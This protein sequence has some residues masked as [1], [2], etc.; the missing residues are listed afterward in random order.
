VVHLTSRAAADLKLMQASMLLERDPAAAAA[1]AG[2]IL[3]ELPD[4]EAAQLLFAAARRRL[5][6]GASALG[7]L[8]SLSEANPDSAVLKLELGRS[9]AAAHD[10]TSALAALRAAVALN[11]NLAQGWRELSQLHF[12]GG[13]ILDGDRAYLRFARLS[14]DPPELTDALVALN[15]DRLDAAE[16]LVRTRLLQAP[17][18]GNA[19]YLLANVALKRGDQ[20]EAERLLEECLVRL[21]GHPGARHDLAK[22]LHEQERSDEALAHIARLRAQDP[23]STS[24][25]LLEVQA[26]RLAG[27]SADALGLM[28]ELMDGQATAECLVIHGNLLREL[29]RQA[30][31]IA[32]Y[33]RAIELQPGYAEAYWALANLK[34]YRLGDEDVEALRRQTLLPTEAR[35]AGL[36]FALGKALEDRQEF[37][38]AFEHYARGNALKRSELDYDAEATE[39]YTQRCAALYSRDFFAAREGWGSTRNDPI[40]IV[41][42]PRSGSTLLEQMLASH[43]S[44]EGTHELPDVPLMALRLAARSDLERSIDYPERLGLLAREEFESMASR[45][46]ARTDQYRSAGR[47]F[48]VDKM[49]GN[50]SHLG[51]IHLMFPRALII[52]A[53]RH[54]MACAFSC[55]KQHFST[56]MNFSYDLRELAGYLRHYALSLQQFDRALPGRVHRVYYEQL[57]RDPKTELTKVLGRCGL[58]FD[59]ACLRF[60]ENPR[61]VKTISSEQV[62]RPLYGDALEQWRH[63]EAW[64]QPLAEELRPLIAD[65]PVEP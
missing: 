35:N 61:V 25:R 64:L 9:L 29:G 44:I 48:F 41:G 51:L 32:Q 56:G 55:F 27:R 21:P 28:R 50:F 18:D 26:L 39:I 6:D 49:L 14:R 47:P 53:R 43:P 31:A 16:S 23:E 10:R 1:G 40:F 8:K 45:Y 5:G 34:T 57:V 17:E 65:Y 4:H 42:L 52:D 13:D 54:P 7:L 24:H 30:E 38:A 3:G 63:F 19:L 22:L 20:V 60:Y 15:D 11:P 37:A 33:R 46:L 36:H 59:E 2:E 62:R 58:P 12:A